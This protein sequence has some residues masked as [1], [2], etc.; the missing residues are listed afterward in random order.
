MIVGKAEINASGSFRIS[1]Q[2]WRNNLYGLRPEIIN[3]PPAANN[4]LK[5]NSL[6]L[7]KLPWIEWSLWRIQNAIL[8][9][10]RAYKCKLWTNKLYEASGIKLNS[11]LEN[12]YD[13][14]K[15]KTR[16][17]V[18]T[19]PYGDEMA[20]SQMRIKMS[21]S[22]NNQRI[23]FP[24]Y[25]NS[26]LPRPLLSPSLGRTLPYLDRAGGGAKWPIDRFFQN[27]SETVEPIFTKFCDFNHNY[28]A[29]L[30]KL[31]V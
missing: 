18:V 5:R 2:Y 7:I 25:R 29:Y 4:S 21:D 24:Q 10:T 8:T 17:A 30:S 13:K 23:T 22:N 28:I 6:L 31:R 14:H 27:S 12:V 16:K 20:A 26:A 9:S 19:S 1:N 11:V 15:L 3:S